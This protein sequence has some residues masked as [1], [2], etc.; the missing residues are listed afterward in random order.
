MTIQP[1][2]LA[3]SITFAI[4]CNAQAASAISGGASSERAAVAAAAELL[5]KY[6]YSMEY[7]ASKV[8]RK[9]RDSAGMY[10]FRV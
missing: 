9:M 10:R 7:D 4:A 1:S 6:A 3:L 5:S 8:A 2:A